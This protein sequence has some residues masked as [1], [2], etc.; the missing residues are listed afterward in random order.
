MVFGLS[1]LSHKD[2]VKGKIRSQVLSIEQKLVEQYMDL[3]RIHE[4]ELK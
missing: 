3:L 1:G 4:M 2:V